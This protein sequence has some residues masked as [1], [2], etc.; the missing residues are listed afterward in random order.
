MDSTS[1]IVF[2]CC[3][4]SGSLESQTIRMIESLRRY[5]GKFSKAPVV[6]VMPRFGSPLDQKTHQIFDRYEIE[7]LVL[8]SGLRNTRYSWNK[9]MN[10]P[11]GILAVNERANSQAIG[12]LDS[13]LL[14]VG[15]PNQLSLRA[16]ESFLACTVDSNGATTGSNDPLE[17]YWLAVCRIL[18]L[19]IDL[20]PWVTTE[21]EHNQIRYYFNS[22]LFVYRRETN[23]AQQYLENC[24]KILDAHI[25]SKSCGYFFTDQ[26][27]LGLTAFQLDL[28]WRPLP[29]SHNFSVSPQK[30]QVSYKKE[31][32]NDARVVHYHGSMWPASWSAFLNCVCDT[33]PEV[34]EWLA[35]LG[36]MQNSAPWQWRLLNK[37]LKS[38]RSRAESAYSRSCQIV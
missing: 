8:P 27:A 32:F 1:D 18:N 14:F 22:G 5:G 17:P 7:Y 12:W 33:H 29:Y 30:D 21:R 11:Y 9:F 20:L 34:G 19:D 4:E 2:V 13:D 10:K 37:L 38:V 26:I 35:S 28:P 25:S 23:F 24:T 3:V 16:N 36:P 31:S 15:E 6:A